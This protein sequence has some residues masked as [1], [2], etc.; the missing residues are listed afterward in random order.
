MLDLFLSRRSTRRFTEEPVSEETMEALARAALSAPTS[1]DRRETRLISVRDRET[2]ASLRHVK[3]FGAEPLDEAQAAMVVLAATER[4]DTWV[5]DASIAAT[6]ILLEAERLGLG[7]CW[8][9][10]R[11]RIGDEKPAEDN[12]RALLGI[13]EGYGVLWVVALGHKAEAKVPYKEAEIDMARFY[14]ERFEQ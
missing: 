11:N 6:Y 14:R 1:R 2:I 8:L 3:N 9:Q 10:I 7:A 13:P 5:E 12:V 4:C